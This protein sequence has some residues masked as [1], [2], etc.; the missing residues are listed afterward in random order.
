MRQAA[1]RGQ[2]SFSIPNN[3]AILG[4]RLLQRDV[5]LFEAAPHDR[6]CGKSLTSRQLL[7]QFSN[8]ASADSGQSFWKRTARMKSLTIFSRSSV[9]KPAL[10]IRVY[11]C[12]SVAKSLVSLAFGQLSK[13]GFWAT[14]GHGYTRIECLGF[15]ETIF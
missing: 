9:R 10:R 1:A 4:I 3:Y 13:F 8:S 11:P 15:T 5:V 2:V 6:F 14:D 7:E 12:P